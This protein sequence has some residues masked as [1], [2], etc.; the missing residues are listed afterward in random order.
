MSCH[1]FDALDLYSICHAN[2]F[3][4]LVIVGTVYIIVYCFFRH[5][6]FQFVSVISFLLVL[7]HN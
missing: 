2:V 7:K 5:Y 4:D 3:S 1:P 6:I